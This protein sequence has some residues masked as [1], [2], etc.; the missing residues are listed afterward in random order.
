MD[1]TDECYSLIAD[2]VS[3]KLALDG[4]GLAVVTPS[5]SHQLQFQ[6]DD[7]LGFYVESHRGTSDDDNG[8]VVLQDQNGGTSYSEVVWY[9]SIDATRR[10]SQSGSCPYSVGLNGVLSASTHGAPVISISITTYSCHQVFSTPVN[11]LSSSIISQSLDPTY[12]YSS[13]TFSNAATRK[14][15]PSTYIV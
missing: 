10:T 12:S 14:L 7:V 2:F 8:V 4:S 1:V 13:Q 3:T 11:L 5:A 15:S 9:G 6:P